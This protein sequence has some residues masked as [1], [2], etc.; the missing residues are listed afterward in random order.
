MAEGA[1]LHK[2]ATVSGGGKSE[3]SKR[4]ED[5]IRYGPVYVND[6][7]ADFDALESIFAKDFSAIMTADADVDHPLKESNGAKSLLDPHVSMGSII[8]LFTPGAQYTPAHNKFIESVPTYLSELLSVIKQLYKQEWKDQWRQHFYTD[9]VNG[10]LGHELKYKGKPVLS[11]VIRV[12]FRSVND[13]RVPL[14]SKETEDLHSAW[15]TFTLRQDFFPCS[16]LQTVS[17]SHSTF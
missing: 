9:A 11:S 15:K 8:K 2:P 5:M 1:N 7:T 3:I 6:I 4:L 10:A 13:A 16:K 17:M 12:G 14:K